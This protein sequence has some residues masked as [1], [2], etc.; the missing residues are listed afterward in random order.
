MTTLTSSLGSSASALDIIQQALSVVQANVSNSS[1]AGY[2]TQQV[3]LQALPMDSATAAGGG[4]SSGG[5]T[6][7]RDPYADAA[8]ELQ[9]Q[10]LGL[11]SSQ[12]QT[13]GTI[14]S[15]F[16]VTGSSGVS[17]ALTSLFTAFSS[18]SASPNDPSTGQNVLA[19]ASNV[20]AT[21]NSLS[22]S[23][24]Q[25]D[26]HVA[27]QAGSTVSEINNIAAQIQQ[28]NVTREKT[29]TDDPGAQ[30]QLQTNLESLANLVNFTALKQADGTITVLAGSGTPLV[31]GDK[32]YSLSSSQSVD[33]VPAPS[34]P[35]SPPTTHIYDSQGNDVTASITGGQLGGLLDSGNRVVAGIIGDSQN[36]GSLNVLAKSLADT[37]NQVLQS[38]TVSTGPGAAAGTALFTYDGSDATLAA[39]TL[40]VDPAVTAAQLAPV[41]AAGNANGNAATLA[42]L[43]NASSGQ[44][45]INGMSLVQYFASIAAGVGQENQTAQVNQQV[46]Q[47]ITTQAQSMRDSISKVSLDGQAALLMQYQRAYQS[48]ARV[49]TVVNGLADSV[50]SLVPQA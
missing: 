37:V 23:L 17:T 8:V 40:T 48:V 25:I 18:W 5:V 28:Y 43:A 11:Y 36:A 50:L 42:G 39:G 19:A 14:Q 32:Q 24:H 33:T 46:Q 29:A 16:D 10:S 27:Q 22:V 2:A 15:L 6:S 41:D 30:A 47:Q 13:T 3:N 26:T 4:L 12:L 9:L 35:N 45:T 49:L 21:I 44:G 38:G 34:N 7:S 20:A 31:M 1:T